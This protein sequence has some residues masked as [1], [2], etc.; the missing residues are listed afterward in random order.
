MKLASEKLLLKM[1]KSLLGVNLKTSNTGV[2]TDAT[3]CQNIFY[4][5]KVFQPFNREKQ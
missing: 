4:G 1:H 5:I 3:A 2:Y